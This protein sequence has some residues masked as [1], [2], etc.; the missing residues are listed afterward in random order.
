[1][2]AGSD[3]LATASTD[4]GNLAPDRDFVYWTEPV[5]GAV[6]KV[7]RKGGAAAVVAEYQMSAADV[8]VDDCFVY[9]RTGTKVARVPK[10]GGTLETFVEAN[11]LARLLVD[12]EAV[13]YYVGDGSYRGGTI[14]RLANTGGSPTVVVTA[15]GSN[16]SAVYIHPRFQL[17]PNHVYWAENR[18]FS[19]DDYILRMSKEGGTQQL[20]LRRDGAEL[21]GPVDSTAAIMSNIMMGGSSLFAW[22][23][24]SGAAPIVT[25][26]GGT[27]LTSAWVYGG[28][29]AVPKCGYGGVVQ[30]RPGLATPVTPEIAV[31]D[32]IYYVSAK[33]VIGQYTA[34]DRAEAP[35][36]G[37]C[38]M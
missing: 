12:L 33:R 4:I 2:P 35:T 25:A 32:R 31:D 5:I 23:P 3:V 20:I 6:M 37:A 11:G 14:Y 10:S 8:Q 16:S 38:G 34:L 19:I 17:G 7:P 26:R 28:G 29:L 30:I 1:M 13:Y 15:S 27:A 21:T 36:P 22:M 18:S 24:T 9:W